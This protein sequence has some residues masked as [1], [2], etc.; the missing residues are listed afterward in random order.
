LA[1]EAHGTAQIQ[2]MVTT[3]GTNTEVTFV[4]DQFH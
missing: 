3:N 1:A 4:I 2:K